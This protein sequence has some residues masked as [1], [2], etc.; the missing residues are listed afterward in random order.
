MGYYK[1]PQKTSEDFKVVD[2]KRW[3][4]TGDIG[5]WEPDGCLRIIGWPFIVLFFYEEE[6]HYNVLCFQDRKKDLVKLQAGEYVSLGKVETV[7]CLNPYVDNI[8]LWADSSKHYTV[9][10]VIPNKKHVQKLADELGI[11]E[12]DWNKLVEDKKLVTAIT[13]HI[14][15]FG[16]KGRCV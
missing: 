5:L 4:A 3:F 1:N 16:L 11:N 10:L 15:D 6:W 2:G 13:K 9:A 14:Q 8:C 7:I 12:Q